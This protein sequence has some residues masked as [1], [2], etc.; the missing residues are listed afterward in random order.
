MIGEPDAY[1]AD[2]RLLGVSP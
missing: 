2:R 1:A